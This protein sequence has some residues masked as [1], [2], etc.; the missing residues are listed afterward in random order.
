MRYELIKSIQNVF[1]S[2]G[3]KD[4]ALQVVIYAELKAT[5]MLLLKLGSD[6]NEEFYRLNRQNI[7]QN[8]A[9]ALVLLLDELYGKAVTGEILGKHPGFSKN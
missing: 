6:G 2:H 8:T 5:Q 3:I 7:E 4:S 9:Q 1:E